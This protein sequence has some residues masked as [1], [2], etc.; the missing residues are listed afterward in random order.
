MT[1]IDDSTQFNCIYLLQTK[2][3]AFEAVKHFQTWVENNTDH[4]ILKLKSDRGGEYSST[5]FLDHLNEL[6]IDMERGPANR[7]TSNGVAERFNRTLLGKM[8]AQFVQSGLPL[9]LWGELAKYTSHQI[10]LSPSIAITNSN[11]ASLFTPHLKEHHH[12][13]APSLFRPFGC[14]AYVHDENAAKLSPTALRAIFVGLEP[15]SNAYRL[16]DK[17]SARIIVS[18]NVTFN[19]SVFPGKLDGSSPSEAS[20]TSFLNYDFL[21]SEPIS[22]PVTLPESQPELAVATDPIP[23]TPLLTTPEENLI[24][25][26]DANLGPTPPTLT[27][28][29]TE[30][31]PRRSSRTTTAPTRYGFVASVGEDTNN[32][33]A[34]EDAMKGPDRDRWKAA[35]DDELDSFCHHNVGTLVEPPSD[36]N[37]LGGMWVLS[38]PCDEHHR[39]IKYKARYLVFGNHQVYGMDFTD[40]YTSVGWSDSMRILLAI[41]IAKGWVLMQFDIKTAFLNGDMRDLVFC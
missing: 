6:A 32:N 12:P 34:Y 16:W 27:P 15:G 40:T 30:N 28:P 26:S 23:D 3:E 7:P 10:N 36:A 17:H 31:P 2:S 35:M 29:L 24:D 37:I 5:E 14:L 19:E 18:S 9:F 11:P 1:F 21:I 33:P 41:A 20:I 39:I 25:S 13:T 8:R 4:K 38:R 22:P